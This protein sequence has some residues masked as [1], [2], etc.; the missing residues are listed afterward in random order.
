MQP[1]RRNSTPPSAISAIRS[2]AGFRRRKG[3]PESSSGHS[4]TNFK[5]ANSGTVGNFQ[6]QEIA[7][8]SRIS[9]FVPEFGGDQDSNPTKR[10]R[11][12]CESGGVRFRVELLEKEET[13][14]ANQSRKCR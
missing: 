6:P 3:L 7:H 8:C 10:S 12:G 13:T 1:R 11:Q 2:S 9:L 14:E 4:A 5:Q